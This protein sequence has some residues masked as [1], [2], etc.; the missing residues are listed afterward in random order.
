MSNMDQEREIKNLCSAIILRAVRDIK[1]FKPD[2]CIYKEA[3][4]FFRSEWFECVAE[5]SGVDATVIQKYVRNTKMEM[6]T[7]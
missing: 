7:S 2:S 4:A 5:L 1:H 6:V 3:E